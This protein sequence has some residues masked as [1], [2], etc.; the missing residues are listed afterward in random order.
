LSTERDITPKAVLQGYDPAPFFFCETN[1]RTGAERWVAW[2]GDVAQLKRLV[3]ALLE[4][5]S[6]HAQV[7]LKVEKQDTADG[8]AWTRYHGDAPIAKVVQ[9]IRENERLIF[10]D[11]Y[12]QL[13]VRDDDTGEYIALDEYDVLYIYSDDERFARICR[14]CGFEERVERLISETAH[15]RRRVPEAEE[16]CRQFVS[17]LDLEEVE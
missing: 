13:C 15:W 12:T 17:V 5:F 7:L 10:Q 2:S 6:L 8:A 1:E 16:F 3:Y 4:T 11:G 9:A 14:Q